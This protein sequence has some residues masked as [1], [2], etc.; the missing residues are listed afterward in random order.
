M[1]NYAGL[2]LKDSTVKENACKIMFRTD[3]EKRERINKLYAES[4]DG[5]D[6]PEKRHVYADLV[7]SYFNPESNLARFSRSYWFGGGSIVR[8]TDGKSICLELLVRLDEMYGQSVLDENSVLYDTAMFS[9]VER[10][11]ACCKDDPTTTI[12]FCG[13]DVS[14]RKNEWEV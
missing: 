7:A 1:E 13:L 8:S 2:N 9:V 3:L 6:I 10:F 14:E 11:G 4:K 5:S 12:E